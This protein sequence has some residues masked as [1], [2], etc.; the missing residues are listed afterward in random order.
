VPRRRGMPDLPSPLAG[1]IT[2]IFYREKCHNF[3]S[4]FVS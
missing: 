2:L 4:L 1:E 3:N